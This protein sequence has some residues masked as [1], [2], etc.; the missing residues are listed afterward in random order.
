MAT[1]TYVSTDLPTPAVGPIV[2]LTLGKEFE[3]T[4]SVTPQN[5]RISCFYKIGIF[6]G[7]QE[8]AP[9]FFM[10]LT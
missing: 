9:S 10:T 1:A 2:S 7:F 8:P 3:L 6:R 5:P 4:I